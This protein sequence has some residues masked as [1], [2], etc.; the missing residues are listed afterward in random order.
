M[1]QL[2]TGKIAVDKDG[3]DLSHITSDTQFHGII[4]A[5]LNNSLLEAIE[6]TFVKQKTPDG[7]GR[8]G[9]DTETKTFIEIVPYQK[10]LADAKAR[11]EAFFAH[12]GF[13]N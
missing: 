8:F 4:V 10:L 9:Y 5:D 6:A 3:R 11:N 2:R 12:L 13:A 1:R 7:L